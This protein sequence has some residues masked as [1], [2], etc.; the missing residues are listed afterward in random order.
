MSPRN[1]V[2]AV[3]AIAIVWTFGAEPAAAQ[4]Y[5]FCRKTEAGAGD[6]RYDS[7]EQC[8]AAVSGTSGYCQPNY[9]LPPVQQGASHRRAR[10]F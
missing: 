8:Q 5:P 1:I 4:P 7:L 10:R 2:L 9:F 6:C 3:A